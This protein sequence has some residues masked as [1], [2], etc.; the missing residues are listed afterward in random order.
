MSDSLSPTIRVSSGFAPT[1]SMQ[2]RTRSPLEQG[3]S[4]PLTLE[5]RSRMSQ[6]STM[7]AAEGVSIIVA[8]ASF[9]PFLWSSIAQ[10]LISSKMRM[11]PRNQA[12]ASARV[13][14]RSKTT[15][16]YI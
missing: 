14:S 16:L 15:N 13:P 6:E 2:R 3:R 10:S 1:S 11:P 5:N 12:E 4:A 7:A 8:I 9:T